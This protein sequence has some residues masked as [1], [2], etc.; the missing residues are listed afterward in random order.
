MLKKC[1]KWQNVLLLVAAL[2]AGSMLVACGDDEADEPEMEDWEEG[3]ETGNYDR[4]KSTYDKLFGTVWA[5]GN[6]ALQF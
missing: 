5:A 2:A 1:L 3:G 6:Q 4:F